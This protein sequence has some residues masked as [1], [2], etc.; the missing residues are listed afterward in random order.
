MIHTDLFPT[1]ADIPNLQLWLDSM[2]LT[3]NQAL[4]LSAAGP[5]LAESADPQAAL[6]SILAR[7]T[8]AD[9][10][11]DEDHLS[12]AAALLAT[13]QQASP[14]QLHALVVYALQ[15]TWI[16]EGATLPGGGIEVS[17]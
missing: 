7:E 12:P 16:S 13:V 4:L 11:T 2:E 14:D 10:S 1:E 5:E 9:A 15:K 3:A 8:P 17:E 6:A